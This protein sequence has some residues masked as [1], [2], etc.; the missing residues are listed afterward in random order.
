MHR[1]KPIWNIS[2]CNVMNKL[3]AAH[4]KPMLLLLNF[5][6][7]ITRLQFIR[8]VEFLFST[9]HFSLVCK[10]ITTVP[11]IRDIKDKS[12]MSSN[13]DYSKTKVFVLILFSKHY[14]IDFSWLHF[15]DTL[16]TGTLLKVLSCRGSRRNK[17]FYMSVIG[18]TE[19]LRVCDENHKS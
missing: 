19:S 13:A 4:F 16:G 1:T 10:H 18:R 11:R 3:Q 2:I 5:E 17:L 7:F 9:I 12:Q 8:V 6:L 14:G 15:W